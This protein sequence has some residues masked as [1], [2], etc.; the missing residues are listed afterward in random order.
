MQ[1]EAPEEVKKLFRELGIELNEVQQ[2]KVYTREQAHAVFSKIL[3]CKHP[4]IDH[5]WVALFSSI[6]TRGA[7]PDEVKG[8]LDA[9]AEFDSCI[10]LKNVDKPKLSDKPLYAI[11]GSGKDTWKTFNISTAAAFVAAS[12][13]VKV[14]KPGSSSVSSVSGNLDVISALQLDAYND[15]EILK[16]AL[17]K[18]GIAVASFHDLAPKYAERY[19][20]A[21]ASFH[22]LSYVLPVAAIPYHLD[23]ISY[24]I[25]DSR[26]EMARDIISDTTGIKN[27]VVASSKNSKNQIT[28]EFSPFGEGSAAILLNGKT[29]MHRKNAPCQ[30]SDIEAIAHGSSHEDNANKI[31]EALTSKR[32][33]P[34]TKAVCAAAA[35]ILHSATG[36]KISECYLD[37]IKAVE[38]GKAYK[39][40]LDYREFCKSERRTSVG[41]ADTHAEVER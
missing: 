4:L 7:K 31:V 6:Q 2:G 15:P 35:T 25:A 26:V 17:N 28:D 13:G 37:A 27:I 36:K 40:M 23:G 30:D 3:A 22:P 20:G 12:L 14:L 9:A 19:D 21:F 41:I 10:K 34:K 38:T 18:T 39:K 29:H 33:N 5:Q 11:C 16:K 24:G 1:Q 32:D 8:F